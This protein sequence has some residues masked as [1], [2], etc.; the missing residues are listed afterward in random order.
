MN[1]FA[2]ICLVEMKPLNQLLH[3]I[4]HLDEELKLGT[5]L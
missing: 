1:F 4:T 3:W 5:I 2:H